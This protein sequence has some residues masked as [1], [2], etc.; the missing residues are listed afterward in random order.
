MNDEKKRHLKIALLAVLI[1]IAISLLL[2]A[3][4]VLVRFLTGGN[5]EGAF[6]RASWLVFLSFG[7]ALLLALLFLALGAFKDYEVLFA[8][9]LYYGTLIVSRLLEDKWFGDKVTL[10]LIAAAISMAIAFV[11][12]GALRWGGGKR[13]G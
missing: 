3:F 13:N 2:G 1:S 12:R 9:I 8:G 10:Y 7:P 11:V 4:A 5:I 6:L